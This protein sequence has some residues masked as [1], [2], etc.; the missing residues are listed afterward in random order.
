[1][2]LILI[3]GMVN[4]FGKIVYT[5]TQADH[6]FMLG[7]RMEDEVVDVEVEDTMYRRPTRFYGEARLSS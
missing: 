7:W 5:D 3:W 1:M 2:L 4:R 6:I